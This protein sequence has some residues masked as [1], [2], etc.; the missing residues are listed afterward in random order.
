MPAFG[1]KPLFAFEGYRQIFARDFSDFR[2][3]FWGG[4]GTRSADDV[5][6]YNRAHEAKDLSLVALARSPALICIAWSFWPMVIMVLAN[7]R[8]AMPGEQIAPAVYEHPMLTLAE[9]KL[10]LALY[11]QAFR[12]FGWTVRRVLHEQLPLSHTGPTS[13][14][15]SR[16]AASP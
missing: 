3:T 5:R 12:A 8:K 16:P 14:R 4:S 2:Q 11:S 1:E 7:G 6:A 9:G 10:R 15:A 13:C